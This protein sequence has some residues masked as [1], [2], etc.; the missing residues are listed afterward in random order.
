[1]VRLDPGAAGEDRAVIP[2]AEWLPDQAPLSGGS[3]IVQNVYARTPTSYGPIGSL[4]GLGNAL[5]A[6]CQGA[7]SYR[8]SDGVVGTFAGDI[9]KLYKW[10]GT[11]WDDVSILAGYAVADNDQWDFAQYGNFVFATDGT[12]NPQYYELGTSAL[13]AD[14][15][16]TPPVARF[17]EG[18]RDFVFLGRL[19]TGQNY[20]QWCEIN[21]PESWGIGVNQ[22]DVQAIP[23]GGRVMG[24]VGGEY[25]IVFMET[26][27]H[28]FI[29]TGDANIV[30]QR[31]EIS[32]ERG[33]V[34]EGS[35]ASFQDKIFFYSYDGF[36]VLQGGANPV[37]ISGQKIDGWSLT[38]IDPAYLY[39]MSSTVDPVRKLYIVSLTSVNS[40][41][42]FND[43][44]LWY[45]WEIGRWTYTVSGAVQA[46]ILA[47]LLTDVGYTG[48][49]FP[50]AFGVTSP[51]DV[52]IS[53]DS[54]LFSGSPQ[55]KLS[56]F[57]TDNKMGFF[58]GPNLE[59]QVQTVEGQITP[60]RQ[61]FV[62]KGWPLTDGGSPQIRLGY[63]KRLNDTVVWT[64]DKDQNATGFCPFRVNS[65]FFQAVITQPAGESWSFIEGI[66]VDQGTTQSGIR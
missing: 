42:T 11:A 4:E 9:D 50:D 51:D 16:D 29:Y 37:P 24:I 6:R 59:A 64:D 61:T 44:T 56:G 54:S 40:Q 21:D 53:P 46:H 22:G 3:N 5:G 52:P 1:M 31:D 66:Q 47:S 2:V 30:F 25:A 12:D 60:G 15:P 36:Y 33:C 35:I 10:D 26:A 62:T 45:N 38:N 32:K 19:S 20:V 27:I 39:R 48:D 28:R 8:G 55:G 43:V 7:A 58:E 57:G 14:V 18:V 17:C 34:A 23:T 41:D 49:N 13:F 63:R 65:R